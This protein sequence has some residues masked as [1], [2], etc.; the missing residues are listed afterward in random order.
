MA[1]QLVTHPE[2]APR[3]GLPLLKREGYQG[4]GILRDQGLEPLGK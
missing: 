3:P 4:V 2:T 1:T